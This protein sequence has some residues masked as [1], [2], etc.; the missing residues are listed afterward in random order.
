ALVH[1]SPAAR[2]GG[3]TSRRDRLAAEIEAALVKRG[4]RAELAAPG[5]AEEA[6]A[7]LRAAPAD[8]YDLAVVAG[9]DGTV[10]LAVGSLAGSEL[11][12]GIVPLGTGNLLAATLGIPRDPSAAAARLATATTTTIDTGVLKSDGVTE[13]FAV[14]A[15]AGFDAR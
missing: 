14:A 6:A 3:H 10:R 12:L 5:S 9:G 15:G 7:L 13:A 4:V 1:I 2:G 8:G 11:P